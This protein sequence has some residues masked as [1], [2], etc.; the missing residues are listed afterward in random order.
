[1]K[2]RATREKR[3][4]WFP[5]D[6]DG[7][8]HEQNP[9][10]GCG[11]FIHHLQTVTFYYVTSDGK[12]P[13]KD[14]SNIL[15]GSAARKKD[16]ENKIGKDWQQTFDLVYREFH[17]PVEKGGCDGKWSILEKKVYQ[18]EEPDFC[19]LGQKWRSMYGN[20]KR[21]EEKEMELIDREEKRQEIIQKIFEFQK[22]LLLEQ[23]PKKIKKIKKPKKH[24]KKIKFIDNPARTPP[25]RNKGRKY[26]EFPRRR[27]CTKSK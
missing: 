24:K 6:K 7:E 25:S 10:D 23:S 4:V 20:Q 26:Q 13:S 14:G 22:K 2:T 11:G 8:P 19:V 12:K 16:K 15:E 21:K 9:D 1:M 17:L 5:V 18:L 3:R 27:R